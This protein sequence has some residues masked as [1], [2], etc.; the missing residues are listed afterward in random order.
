MSER[1]NLKIPGTKRDT[2]LTRPETAPKEPSRGEQFNA[3]DKVTYCPSHGEREHGIV[4]FVPLGSNIAFVV[5]K[6]DNQ[7]S[8]YSDFTGC[9]T[10]VNNL[11]KGWL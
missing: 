2:E 1:H 3:G 6:C 4:K 7:W 11:K 10:F 5:Y 9:A 8:R